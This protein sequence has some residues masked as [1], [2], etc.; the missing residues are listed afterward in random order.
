MSTARKT[1]SADRS[2]RPKADPGGS[3]LEKSGSE[4]QIEYRERPDEDFLEKNKAL[5]RVAYD[6]SVAAINDQIDELNS[7]R[8]RLVQYLA[9]IGAATAFLTGSSLTATTSAPR[10]AGFYAI[11]GAA[12]AL[13]IGVICLT[14]AILAPASSR[15]ATSSSAYAIVEGHIEVDIPTNEGHLLRNLAL[16]NDQAVDDNTGVLNRLRIQYVAAIAMG[17]LQLALLLALVWFFG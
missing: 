11:A 14:V 10:S 7:M 12:T 2:G 15:M 9:F 4:P 17:A 6:E 8:Q 16:L 3:P 13:I 5:Y 1:P